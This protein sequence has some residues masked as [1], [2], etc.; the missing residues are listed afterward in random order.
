M[1]EIVFQYDADNNGTRLYYCLRCLDQG[2]IIERD[3]KTGK[4][5][6]NKTKRCDCKL[7]IDKQQPLSKEFTEPHRKKRK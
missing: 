6:W 7:Q 2:W 1:P 4:P 3:P 5:I